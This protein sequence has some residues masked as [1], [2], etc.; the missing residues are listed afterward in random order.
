MKP[1]MPSIYWIYYYRLQNS[2][3]IR[4]HKENGHS[5]PAETSTA[6]TKPNGVATT[7]SDANS[8]KDLGNKCVKS[9][10]YEGAIENYTKAIEIKDDPVFYSNRALCFLKLEQ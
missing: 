9:N 3:P 8:Y 10:D 1:T 7:L 6:E 4:S 5:K 2:Y